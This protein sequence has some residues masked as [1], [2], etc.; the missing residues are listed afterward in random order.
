MLAVA[1]I[2]A[3]VGMATP[4]SAE[5]VPD[6]ELG[7][8]PQQTFIQN[9]GNGTEIH[10]SNVPGD[11][12]AVS[13]WGAAYVQCLEDGRVNRA[14]ECVENALPS[15]PIVEVQQEPLVIIIHDEELL[16]EACQL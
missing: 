13:G 10:V 6:C 9:N 11:A 2:G 14:I 8:P 16:Q 5:W 3:T 4:A 15:E 12:V 7:P 1:V